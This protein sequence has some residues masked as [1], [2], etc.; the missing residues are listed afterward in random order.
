MSNESGATKEVRLV[1]GEVAARILR[2]IAADFEAGSG[3]CQVETSD[4]GSSRVVTIVSVD[5]TSSGGRPVT[6]EDLSDSELDDLEYHGCS[7]GTATPRVVRDAV[8][9]A[10]QEIRRRRRDQAFDA[11]PVTLVERGVSERMVA[12]HVFRVDASDDSSDLCSSCGLLVDHSSH[13]VGP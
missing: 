7:S 9:R 3:S 11:A 2:S 10:T 5:E 1:R 12:K 4:D 6:Q 13:D 8:V